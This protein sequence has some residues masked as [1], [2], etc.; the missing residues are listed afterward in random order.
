[1]NAAERAF[2]LI[3]IM[4]VLAIVAIVSAVVV[5]EMKG[6]FQD[7]LLRSTGR[8]L[9]NVIELASSRAI[10]LN[11]TIQIKLDPATGHYQIERQLREGAMRN[12]RRSRMS[13]AARG[14]LDKRIAVKIQASITDTDGQLR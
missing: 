3:E 6:T 10:S 2:T 12:L 5:P 4:T 7:S 13:P 11:Q 14:K 8:D 9:V 1:M